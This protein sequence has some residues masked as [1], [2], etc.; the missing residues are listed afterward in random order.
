MVLT[1]LLFTFIDRN[2][3]VLISTII[4]KYHI[5]KCPVEKIKKC[6]KKSSILVCFTDEIRRSAVSSSISIAAFNKRY[7]P[8]TSVKFLIC[9]IWKS[10]SLKVHALGGSVSSLSDAVDWSSMSAKISCPGLSQFL[11]DVSDVANCLSR[12]YSQLNSCLAK[13]NNPL[14]ES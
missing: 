1:I 2:I 3:H 14:L 12:W 13:E 6:Y 10:S 4:H 11:T 9:W 5:I 8:L 7:L